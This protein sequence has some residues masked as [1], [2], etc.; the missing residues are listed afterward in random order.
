[1]FC[2][3]VPKLKR[4]RKQNFVRLYC[5]GSAL[6]PLCVMAF[7]ADVALL[8]SEDADLLTHVSP[9]A[10]YV[11]PGTFM[12]D[13]LKSVGRKGLVDER[14]QRRA[15]RSDYHLLLEHPQDTQHVQPWR[16][17]CMIQPRAE[18]WGFGRRL[19]SVGQLETRDIKVY[20][21]WG[22]RW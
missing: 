12:C 4:H 7:S 10:F 2:A 22:S 20:F 6:C 13:G 19:T 8:I 11:A 15:G 21:C 3:L 5:M 9:A 1:M 16:S 18:I 14:G 17:R